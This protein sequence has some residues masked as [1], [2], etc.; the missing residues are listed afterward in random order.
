MENPG[1]IPAPEKASTLMTTT[2]RALTL[3][4]VLRN[5]LETPAPESGVLSTYLDTRLG[6][7]GMGHPYLIAFKDQTRALR[8][9]VAEERRKAFDR[10]VEQTATYLETITP[11]PPGVAVFVGDEYFFA[12]PLPTRPVDA[13]RFMA[14]PALTPLEAVADDLERVAAL[15][16][17]KERT[18][19]FTIA[20]GE[21]EETIGFADDVPGKQQTGG[22][23]GLSQKRFERHHE[24]HVLRHAKRTIA[25]LMDELRRHPLDRLLIAGP[26]EAIALLEDHLPR[27]LR[28]R[29]AGTLRLE[30]FASDAE[31]LAA[32]RAA[33]EAIEER[34]DMQA[35]RELLDD[36]GSLRVAL[37]PDS[38]LM[39]ITDGRVHQLFLGETFGGPGA[40]CP[41]CGG[42]LPE[43]ETCP[44]CGAATRPVAEL[45]ERAARLTIEKE[46]RVEFLAGE[47]A[48][49]LAPY[50]EIG[51]RTR[52]G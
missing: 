31:V 17:D 21:I 13:V 34:D 46:G 39:A 47:A 12:T 49:L 15:L 24:D 2:E 37:G 52:W 14:E 29:Q 11:G 6:P 9:Q 35:V 40:E 25:A 43:V 51:A 5:L 33:L 18:R 41:A 23:Y 3:P 30:L 32:T 7:E 8:E 38:V 20:I 48:S 28:V 16:F 44:R 50:G 19:L 42:L 22:W 26:D 27:P 36:A 4:D 45:R 10:A 1:N